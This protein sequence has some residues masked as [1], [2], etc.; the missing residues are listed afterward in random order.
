MGIS[1]ITKYLDK[2]RDGDI[3]A[4]NKWRSKLTNCLDSEGI[5]RQAAYNFSSGLY[6]GSQC[7]DNYHE[8][9]RAMSDNEEINQFFKPWL[10]K[11]LEGQTQQ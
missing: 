8:V 4:R 5:S 3:Q 2:I 10:E 1:K 7:S 11:Y 6:L 9:I